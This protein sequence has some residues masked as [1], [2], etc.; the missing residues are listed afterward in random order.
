[1]RKEESEEPFADSEAFAAAD[2]AHF[3]NDNPLAIWNEIVEMSAGLGSRLATCYKLLKPAADA[4]P[5]AK[6]PPPPTG[7]RGRSRHRHRHR[8]MSP[9]DND[10]TV[11]KKIGEE[12]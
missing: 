9:P 2:S 7:L 11:G 5:M 1:M 10:C 12:K 6:N 8:K 4:V 3:G